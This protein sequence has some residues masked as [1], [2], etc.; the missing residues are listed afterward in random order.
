[1]KNLLFVRTRS[2]LSVFHK[3]TPP[4][5]DGKFST[6]TPPSPLGNETLKSSTYYTKSEVFR[7]IFTSNSIISASSSISENMQRIP[8][9]AYQNLL[10]N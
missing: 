2:S 1:M 3:L 6:I 8:Y 10:T 4:A 9:C 7:G 5:Y